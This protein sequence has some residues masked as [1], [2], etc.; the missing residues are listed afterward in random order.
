[1]KQLFIISL[2]LIFAFQV[3]AQQ[4]GKKYAVKS[5]K[6][7]Y[8]LT[9]NTTGTKT[10]Y[11]DDYG[12]KYYEQ[13]KS[14]SITKI[15]GVTDRTEINKIAIINKSHFWTVN[16]IDGNN[17]EGELPYYTSS[18]S[19]FENMTEAEQ[20]KF[21]DDLLKSFGGKREGIEK[22]LGY[23]CEKIGVMGSLLWIYKGITLKSETEVMGIVANETATSFEKNISIPASKFNA[24]SGVKFINMQQQQQA[25]FGDMNMDSYE[26]DDDYDE[27]DIV[28]VK[29]AF[30]DFK[31]V[32]NNFN[33]DGYVRAM[34]MSQDGQHI[35]LYTS[36]G[37]TN[38]VSVI[39]TAMENAEDA[40][41]FNDFETFRHNGK[42]MRY[43]DI[44][45]DDMDGKALIIPYEEHNMYIILMNSPGKD[46][47][48]LLD[49]ADQLDF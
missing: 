36:G 11:F 43:G 5:G 33:P 10:V 16:K 35:A 7:E 44:S 14:V 24:P 37:F 26:E 28:P 8:K 39:A 2:S 1:M 30:S 4:S 45:E 19:V 47:N 17:M 40:G 3:Q 32:I 22:I 38:V 41:E 48:T 25:M 34:V 31:S 18:K 15:F 46:K 27:E 49:W 42:T 9:G 21:A 6:I 20:K 12:D 13:L 23:T 29:Y